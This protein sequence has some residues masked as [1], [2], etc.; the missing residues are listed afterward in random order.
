MADVRLDNNE[1]KELIDGL[2]IY[3]ANLHV[4]YI[5]LHN[6]HWNIVG[7]EFFQV[8]E[9]LEEMYNAVAKEIDE[10]AER[11]RQLGSVPDA[12]M[13]VYIERAQL[14]GAESKKYSGEEVMECLIKDLNKMIQELRDGIQLSD[15]FNDEV[16]MD[17]A[18]ASLTRY[19]KDL[20]MIESYLGK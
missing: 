2:N 12:S 7:K 3:L 1:R 4:L 19:E 13:K 20:W 11:V 10:M 17:I 16:T 9:K 5:K 14:K 18:I 15:K 8:H 6:F